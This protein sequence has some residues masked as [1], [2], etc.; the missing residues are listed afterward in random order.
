MD[1]IVDGFKVLMKN[2]R[3]DF[4]DNDLE[5]YFDEYGQI[6]YEEPEEALV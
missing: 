6:V 5:I 2:I 1:N 3:K 4:S